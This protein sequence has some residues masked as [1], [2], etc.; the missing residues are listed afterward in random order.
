MTISVNGAAQGIFGE[1]CG[2]LLTF[3]LSSKKEYFS[4]FNKLKLIRRAT[5]IN[6]NETL[7]LHPSST[8]FGEYPDELKRRMETPHG[9][10]WTKT[11]ASIAA[12][13]H[14]RAP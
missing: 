4:F 6:D 3:D 8:I 5:N 13:A 14:R 9:I 1:R 2:A 7:A 12:S 10:S 11:S